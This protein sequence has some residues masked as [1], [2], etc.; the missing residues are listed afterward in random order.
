MF[1]SPVD[2]FFVAVKVMDMYFATARG[3]TLDELHEV[4][5]TCMFIASKSTELEPLTIDL[6][7]KK[8]S[9]GK[10]S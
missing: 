8:A 10:V 2:T 9:N 7:V 6:M 3:L 1:K 5:V 4:G